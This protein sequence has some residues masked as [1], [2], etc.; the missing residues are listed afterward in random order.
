MAH[1]ASTKLLVGVNEQE[2][3]C[4]RSHCTADFE[5]EM[6]YSQGS[7]PNSTRR[8]PLRMVGVPMARSDVTPWRRFQ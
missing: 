3:V 7:W 4:P 2:G 8:G 5:S 1:G 6:T